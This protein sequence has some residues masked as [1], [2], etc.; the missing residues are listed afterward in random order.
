MQRGSPPQLCA[1]AATISVE[2]QQSGVGKPGDVGPS[3]ASL[4]YPHP[5]TLI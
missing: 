2:G 3:G 1:I 4:A 5:L